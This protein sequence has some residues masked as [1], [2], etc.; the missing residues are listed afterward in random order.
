MY[1]LSVIVNL[2]LL[3]AF[4]GL[5]YY[6]PTHATIHNFFVVSLCLHVVSCSLSSFSP[7]SFSYPLLPTRLPTIS[8]PPLMELACMAALSL[9]SVCSYSLSHSTCSSSSFFVKDGV[10]SI[11]PFSSVSGFA[12][13]FLPFSYIALMVC[14]WY[15]MW[16]RPNLS[17]IMALVSSFSLFSWS[18]WWLLLFVC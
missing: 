14:S 6:G 13:I 10:S 5:L 1:I 12:I 4:I 3:F 9:S 11:H 17:F 15:S 18:I 8:L 7:L 2:L 16:K